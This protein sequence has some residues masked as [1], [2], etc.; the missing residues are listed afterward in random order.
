LSPSD[1]PRP[2]PQLVD[3]DGDVLTD[4]TGQPV[5]VGGRYLVHDDDCC[6]AV[7]FRAVLVEGRENGWPRWHLTFDNGV[8]L[9]GN[10]R[11]SPVGDTDA[12]DGSSDPD[13]YPR[14]A[15]E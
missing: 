6:M 15:P 9:E 11:L 2:T 5:T 7:A 10:P 12:T 14:G 1:G 4:D 13:P 3:S 8:V